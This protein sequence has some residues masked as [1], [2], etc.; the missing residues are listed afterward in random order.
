MTFN[1]RSLAPYIP[2]TEYDNV[3]EAF[4]ECYYPEGLQSPRAIPILDVARNKMGI[5]VQFVSLSEEFDVYGLTVFE[6][7]NVEVY[8]PEEG[9]YEA[10]FF[11]RKTILID[12]EAY[13]RTNVGCVNNTIAHECVH[14]YKHRLFFLKQ[15]FTLPRQAKFCRCREN[16]LSIIDREL[17]I[18]E[19]QAN[20][21]APRILMP[22]SCFL[23][24][25][26]AIGVY[27]SRVNESQ[28]NELADLFQVSKKSVAIRIKECRTQ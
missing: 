11:K 9:L 14:W 23:E 16:Q 25:A 1:M 13:K 12:P 26:N 22:K 10:K 28:L 21:I 8:N 27:D 24:A 6:D 5:D 3:A 7:G 19:N 4:L 15:Q 20:G 18:L 2:A 17:E